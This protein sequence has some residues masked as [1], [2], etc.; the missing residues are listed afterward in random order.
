MRSLF[1]AIGMQRLDRKNTF[2]NWQKSRMLEVVA[3]Y[4]QHSLNTLRDLGDRNLRDFTTPMGLLVEVWNYNRLKFGAEFD[5]R[6]RSLHIKVR[7]DGG[8][9]NRPWR[10][11][12]DVCFVSA[13][14]LL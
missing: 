1:L 4:Q 13:S 8:C 2:A 5:D 7:H 10:R 6:T 9:V 11:K 14:T 3:E 12:E